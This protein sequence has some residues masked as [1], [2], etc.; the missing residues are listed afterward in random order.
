[1]K[2]KKRTVY[3]TG[4]PAAGKSTTLQQLR[5]LV[6]DIEIWEYARR[7]ADY[8]GSKRSQQ[9]S[10]SELRSGSATIVSPKDIVAVD[11]LLLNYVTAARGK[12]HIIIDSHP[13]TKEDYGFRCTPFSQKQIKAIRPDEI[14]TLYADPITTIERVKAHGGGRKQV[15]EEEARMHTLLQ[16]NIATNYGISAGCPVYFFDSG[17]D[18]DSLVRRLADRLNK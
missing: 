13:V 12:K 15:N 6:N 5:G 14:W 10:H 18:Q 2:G 1:M 7:L 17:S 3:L 9:V 11:M 4:A 16:A 8:I